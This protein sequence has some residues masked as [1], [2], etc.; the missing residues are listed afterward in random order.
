MPTTRCYYEV[1]SVAR[2]ATGD[3]IKRSYRRLAMKFHPDR[4]PDDS[5]AEARFK[6]AAE[7]YEVL[8][9]ED[10]RRRY[11]RHGRE[12]LRGR[13]GHDFNS[14][15][16][17]DI[18]SMFN[19]IFDGMGGPRQSRRASARGFDLETE[20]DLDL[21]EVLTGAEREVSFTR[22]DVCDACT[23]SGA[24]LGSSPEPCGTCGGQGKVAQ[25]GLGGMF[26]MVTA[27]PSCRGRGSVVTNPCTQC[28]GEGRSPTDR[29][30]SVRIPPGIHDGQA[31]RVASEG[32]PPSAEGDPAGSGTRGDLHV[33]V[34][35]AAD[36]RFERD[37]TN[38]LLVQPVAFTQLALGGEVD[39]P[40]LGEDDPW[41]LHLKAGTQ[42]GDLI[43]VKD[44]GVPDLRS[45]HRGDLIVVLKLVVPRTLDQRQRELLSDYA[46]LESTPVDDKAPSMWNR[47]KDAFRG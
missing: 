19:D 21:E 2:G 4:N 29:R 44:K 12:G 35:I 47:I 22:M 39:V 10:R 30:L 31:V 43:R 32:E 23:G 34:R 14:M 26:R 40:L 27:C 41:V 25:A 33:V 36:D 45:G 37:G 6:E 3:D 24:A 28:A 9:D 1:L 15:R 38:L 7:A 16:P 46:K 17:D 11:D 42:P 18:F 5:E 8:S 20:V 13:P